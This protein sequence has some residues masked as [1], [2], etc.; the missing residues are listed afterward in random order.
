MLEVNESLGDGVMHVPQK[1]DLHRAVMAVYDVRLASRLLSWSI[2][3]EVADSQ[4]FEK[5]RTTM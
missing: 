5:V 2:I 1:V 4:Y 3:M